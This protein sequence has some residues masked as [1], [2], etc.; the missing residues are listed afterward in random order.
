MD[1]STVQMSLTRD[2]EVIVPQPL[3][4]EPPPGRGQGRGL[5]PRRPGLR[6]QGLGGGQVGQPAPAARHHVHLGTGWGKAFSVLIWS[7]VTRAPAE[8]VNWPHACMYLPVMREGRSKQGGAN[9]IRMCFY[10]A[11]YFCLNGSC[12]I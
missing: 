3:T 12:F 6:Q 11:L 8:L 4:T 7:R 9:F 1:S 5:H 10:R 2:D